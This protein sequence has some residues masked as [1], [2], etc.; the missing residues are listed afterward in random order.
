MENP[1]DIKVKIEGQ[2]E[3]EDCRKAEAEL[4]LICA[5]YNLNLIRIEKEE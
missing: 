2:V 1:I 4:E 3:Y 5:K